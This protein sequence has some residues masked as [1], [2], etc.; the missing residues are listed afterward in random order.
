[1]TAAMTAA[2]TRGWLLGV[3]VVSGCWTAELTYEDPASGALRLVRNP[4]STAESVVLDFVVGDRAVTG[5]AAGFNLPLDA[6][7][8]TLGAFTPGGALD[9]GAAPRAARAVLPTEGPLAGM[10][11]TAQSQKASGV[12]AVANDTE[13]APGAVLYTVRLELIHNGA[14]GVV[15]DGTAPS[16]VLPS[17]GLRSRTGQTVVDASAVGVGKLEVR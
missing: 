13:L 11:V 4:A 12:G 10:L 14:K 16:F 3:V 5:Y 2:V 7:V 8:V 1:M 15:F 6:G 9:P 17:G